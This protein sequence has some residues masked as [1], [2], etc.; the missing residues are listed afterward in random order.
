MN[1]YY[2]SINLLKVSDIYQLE[3]TKFM[4][5][6]NHIIII[7]YLKTL[8]IILNQPKINTPTQPNQLVIKIII[9][10]D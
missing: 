2:K 4:Y 9:G 1:T 10:K 8:I 5:I 6:I 3:L 7:D